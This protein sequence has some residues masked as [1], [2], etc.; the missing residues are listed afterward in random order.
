MILIENIGELA[1]IGLSR[2]PVPNSASF[3]T[4]QDAFVLI[5][6]GRIR[7]FG[8]MHE[9]PEALSPRT[10]AP[11]IA[12][13]RIDAAG[14]AVI[15]GLIDAHTHL[16]FAGTREGEF[17]QRAQGKSYLE[18]AKSGGGILNTV[19]AVRS[20]DV[21]TLVSLGIERLD[22]MLKHGVTTV[23][24]KS[25]Y[26]LTLEDELK[27]LEVVKRLDEA[28][29]IRC[30]PTYLAAHTIPPEFTD[31]RTAYVDLVVSDE[32]MGRVVSEGL[33]EFCD[34][35]C[36]AS[37]FTLDEARR[38][39]K[40]ASRRGMKLKIHA[41]Q[42]SQIG[43]SRLAVELSAVSAEHLEH[44]DEEAMHALAGSEV[45][46]GLLPGCSFFLGVPQAPARR[47]MD[48]GVPVMIATD[49][50]PGSSMV[51]S[52]PLVVSIACVQMNVA[53]REALLAVTVNA[54][55]AVGRADRVGR[56][57]K[58]LWADLV[59]LD[60]PG[61]DRFAYEVGR[62]GVRHV[63]IDGRVEYS[64][65]DARC[66]PPETIKGRGNEHA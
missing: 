40:E 41:D 59:V 62:D 63:L 29:P 45:I 21:D 13:Q 30:V 65:D 38:V 31:D 32:L 22:R 5:E 12:C 15:P 36:E 14:G 55:A 3:E 6:D 23:E 17:V 35:F 42:L 47:L 57:D 53:P 49:Y 33:A 46:A 20:T 39:L 11:P 25:G 51:E 43:A 61:F 10:T 16:V 18:I 7:D 2:S 66:S 50:N 44:M 4:L 37:A 52:L 60:L 48:A 27:I 56:I 54:A 9:L 58:G 28:H 64:R 19:G 24:I 26:G 8:P 1:P 34:V